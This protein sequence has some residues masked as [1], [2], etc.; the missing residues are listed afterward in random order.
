MHRRILAVGLAG[1]VSA[2]GTFTGSVPS[3]PDREVLGVS[4]HQP[5]L[6]E[7]AAAD[8]ATARTLDWKASQLCTTGTEQVR[9]DVEPAESDQQ[10]VDRL[11]RCRPY[12]L[13]VLGVPLAGIV[14][15]L[16]PGDADR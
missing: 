7:G 14:P 1:L 3:V 11:L 6:A 15:A 4:A 2:C 9:Q 16:V 10:L 13:S 8:D 12:G 5:I